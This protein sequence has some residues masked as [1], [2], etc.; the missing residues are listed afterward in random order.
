MI[1]G[2]NGLSNSMADNH[3]RMESGASKIGVGNGTT[4]STGIGNVQQSNGGSFYKWKPEG[5]Y[6]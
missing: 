3:A 2:I 4:M 1:E 6:T 5:S